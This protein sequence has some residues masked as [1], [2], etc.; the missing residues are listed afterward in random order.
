M[1]LNQIHSE[2]RV[3]T[4]ADRG[5]KTPNSDTPY[6]LL[7]ADLRAEPLVICVPE[8]E[9]GRYFSVRM[10]HMFTHNYGYLVTRTTGNDGG[11]LR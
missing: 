2:A 6:T 4:P 11:C 10:V 8:A 9:K 3:Y 1:S 7:G 5:V